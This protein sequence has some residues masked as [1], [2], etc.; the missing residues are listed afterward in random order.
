MEIVWR[1]AALN[2]LESIRDFIAQDNPR[3]AAR[4]RTAIQTTIDRLAQ[5]PRLGRE[6]RVA[7]TRE[8][9]VPNAPYVVVYRI[10]ENQVRILA[11]LHTA[12]RWPRRF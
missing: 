7:G 11:V 12:R 8:L 3:A 1:A 10:V 5:F 9:V 6:G 2:D 4:V